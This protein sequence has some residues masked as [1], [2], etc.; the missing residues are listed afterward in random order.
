LIMSRRLFL[1][2]VIALVAGCSGDTP[3]PTSETP[4]TPQ[5]EQPAG[6]PG[7]ATSPGHILSADTEY[8]LDGPQQSRPPDGT[9]KAG[10]KVTVIE[11]AGSYCRVRSEDGIV[12]FIAADAINK[13]DDAD[14]EGAP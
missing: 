6:A 8:Y 11:D 10:M 2:L 14:P 9:L 7:S 4:A 13:V 5:A 1:P 12:A 3:A